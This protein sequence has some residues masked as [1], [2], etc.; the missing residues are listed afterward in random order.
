MEGGRLSF[1]SEEELHD[2]GYLCVR[3][4]LIIWR[5]VEGIC[6]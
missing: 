6:E 3:R 2:R 5:Q 4:G 1:D